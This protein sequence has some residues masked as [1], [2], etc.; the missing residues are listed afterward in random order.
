MEWILIAVEAGGAVPGLIEVVISVMEEVDELWCK[1][2]YDSWSE[3]MK[4]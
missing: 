2:H 1:I 3:N 4:V